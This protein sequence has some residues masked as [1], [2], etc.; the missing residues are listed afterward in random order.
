MYKHRKGYGPQARRDINAV[1]AGTSASGKGPPGPDEPRIPIAAELSANRAALTKLLGNPPDLALREFAFG[2]DQPVSCLVAYIDGLTDPAVVAEHLIEPLMMAPRVAVRDTALTRSNA[3]DMICEHLASVWH[4]LIETD[5]GSALKA[6]LGG[7]CLVFIDGC[8]RC[9]AV[10][11]K[12][13]PKR[14]ITTTETEQVIRGPREGFTETLRD[15]TGLVRK[16]LATPALRLEALSLGR[17]SNTAVN[18]VWLQG[19]AS[20][21]IVA[22]V[23]QRLKRIDIDGIMDAGYIEELI[24]DQPYSPFST[25]YHTERPDAFCAHLLEG[26]IGILVDGSSQALIVPATLTMFFQS[27]EDYYTRFHLTIL[28]RFIRLLASFNS[29]LLPPVYIAATTFHHNLIPTAFLL[30][31]AAGRES[32]PFPAV[33]EALFMV[34]TFEAVR[35]AGVRL[36]GI[37]GQAVS[38]VGALVIGQAVVS[39]GVV[40]PIMVIIIALTE[41]GSFAVPA[42]D[43][44]A[45]LR[46]LRYPLMLLAAT[47]GMFGIAVSLLALLI[48]L[49]CLRSFGVPYLDG[50]TPLTAQSAKDVFVRAP[51]PHMKFRPRL[52]A[53]KHPERQAEQSGTQGAGG[54]GAP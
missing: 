16:R 17:L 3:L 29:L 47:L 52:T 49:C 7:V 25:V 23:R 48:H 37:I 11:R 32:V 22:E 1:A 41:V 43:M 12:E 38:I 20:D 40:S 27:P 42:Y 19:V 21:K 46:L 28:I 50:L 35:E 9:L 2:I 34:F 18:I 36:P 4:L 45:T 44:A 15:C 33:I 39:A 5:L 13:P 54:G 6:L 24:E 51:W 31:I 30:S 10:G 8:D 53:Q 14:Q 26:R